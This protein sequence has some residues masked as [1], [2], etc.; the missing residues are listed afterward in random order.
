MVCWV[1]FSALAS[2]GF[3]FYVRLALESRKVA[4]AIRAIAIRSNTTV[5]RF[6][7]ID[8]ELVC[9][10]V[11]CV[12]DTVVGVEF[13]FFLVFLGGFWFRLQRFG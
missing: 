5:A 1:F 2:T 7:W 13:F 9:V 8:W 4:F 6:T 12:V 10:A 3:L 11:N